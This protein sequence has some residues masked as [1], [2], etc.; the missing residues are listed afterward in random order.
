[1]E[2]LGSESERYLRH[3]VSGLPIWVRKELQAE[4]GDHL[5]E[6]IQRRVEAGTDPTVAEAEALAALGPVDELQRE[7]LRV[8]RRRAWRG[9]LADAL[10]AVL[11]RVAF[12]PLRSML[13]SY[14]FQRDYPLGRY[15]AIIVRGE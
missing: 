11:S 7:L 8:H 4:L 3:V 12:G 10:A 15:D 9:A 1:M 14:S 13:S 5:V 6:S 2:R